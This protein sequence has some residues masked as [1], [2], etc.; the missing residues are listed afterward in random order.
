MSKHK[1]ILG[2]SVLAAVATLLLAG[3]AEWESITPNAVQLTQL[4]VELPEGPTKDAIMATALARFDAAALAQQQAD[5]RALEAQQAQQAANDAQAAA[6]AAQA[7]HQRQVV[8]MTQEAQAVERA[9]ADEAQATRQALDSAARE[10]DIEATRQAQEWAIE[11]T[12]QATIVESTRQAEAHAAEATATARAQA[13]EATA[14]AEARSATA[15]AQAAQ[16]TATAEHRAAQ[17]VLA[18]QT[19]VVEQMNRESTAVAVAATRQAVQ[20]EADRQRFYH[21]FKIGGLILLAVII[22]LAVA[23]VGWR[24]FDLFESRAR[25]VRRKADEGEPIWLLDRERWAM[26]LRSFGPVVDA[27]PGKER[28]PLL[29]PTIEAQEGATARQQTSNL[30]QATQAG[31]LARAKHKPASHTVIL[32]AAAPARL[33][34]MQRK[35]EPGLLGPIEQGGIP[36]RLL[37][38]ISGQWEEVEEA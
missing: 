14:T 15:T 17:A 31:E 13:V 24:L 18:T 26:P 4:A 10:N 9:R 21:P 7:E 3:C 16:A 2:T 22:V 32:P 25:L 5:Q 11:A 29:A 35:Q 20:L 6:Q 1:L 8:I 27:T 38:A 34:P 37:E 30:A 36:S 28:A 33:R 12:R 19:A 23:Y